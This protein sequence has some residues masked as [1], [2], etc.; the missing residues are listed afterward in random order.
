MKITGQKRKLFFTEGPAPTDK[1]REE[2]EMLGAT[3][4]R[5]AKHPG[6]V[7]ECEWVSGKVP[8]NYLAAKVKVVTLE[9]AT[10]PKAKAP[11][12]K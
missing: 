8:E 5:N 9:K 12:G 3:A 4:F 11:E 7:E 10:A 1:E 2:A 6:I